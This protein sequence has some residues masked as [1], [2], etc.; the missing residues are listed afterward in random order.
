MKYAIYLLAMLLWACQPSQPKEQPAEQPALRKP[1]IQTVKFDAVQRLMNSENDT[2]YVVNFWATWCKPCVEELP[3]FERL[4]QKYAGKPVKVVLIS[5]DFPNQL[6][7]KL[8]PFVEKHSMQSEVWLLDEPDANA[9]IDKVDPSWDGAI[10]VTLLINKRK[11]VSQ[12]IGKEIGW[13]A[14]DMLTGQAL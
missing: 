6:N 1:G 13:E 7:T 11:G 10:P 12:F 3:Y 14:L 2:L 5:L 8:I 4:T 9:W